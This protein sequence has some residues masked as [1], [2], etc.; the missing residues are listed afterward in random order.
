MRRQASL[1]VLLALAAACAEGARTGPAPIDREVFIETYVEL[2]LAALQSPDYMVTPERRAAVLQSQGVD[3][4]ALL[5]FADA[6][7]RD[8]EYMSELWSEVERRL[9]A[10]RTEEG[11]TR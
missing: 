4:D 9:E 7:G 10:R 11:A 5:A 6:H 3:A 1:A 2:R 8:V